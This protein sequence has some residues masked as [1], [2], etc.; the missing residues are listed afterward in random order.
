MPQLQRIDVL[1]H[2]SQIARLAAERCTIGRFRCLCQ[3]LFGIIR[4]VFPH[5]GRCHLRVIQRT[6]CL[7]IHLRKACRDKQAALVGQALCNR[8]RR[9]HHA[10]IDLLCCKI[11]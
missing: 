6:K 4:Q 11:A 10:V 1:R 9:G 7:D 5:D 3:E 2:R 8:L